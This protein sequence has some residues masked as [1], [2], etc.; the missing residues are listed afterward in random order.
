MKKIF[1]LAVLLISTFSLVRA[2]GLTFIGGDTVNYSGQSDGNMVYGVSYCKNNTASSM[3]V[4]W[5]VIDTV[6][7]SAWEYPGFCD[8]N[9]CYLFQINSTHGFTLAANEQGIM[10]IEVIGN[11]VAGTGHATLM[12]WNQADSANSVIIVPYVARLNQAAA[13]VAGISTVE[14]SRI[15]L[16]P[17]PVKEEAHLSLPSSFT[18][19]QIDIYNLIG[20]KVFSQAVTREKELDLSSL[21]TG[22][23]IAR[24][25][26]NGKII[27][28]RKFTKAE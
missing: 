23:Y 5:K 7:P 1:T 3:D 27:A 12:V 28:T 15:A 24:I 11:C 25:S 17:N 21:G 22:L 10:K 4:A 9:L 13:C 19:G 14:A 8:K 2:Q 6:G 16:Y 26:E 18:A 20:S